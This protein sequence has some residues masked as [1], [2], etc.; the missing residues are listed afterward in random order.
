MN[1][2]IVIGVSVYSDYKNNLPGCKNDATAI[3]I[4]LQKTGKFQKILY[5]NENQSSAET[6]ELITNF[7]LEFKGKEIDEFFFYYS[8][9]G[10]FFNNEFYY[11]LSDFDSKKRNQSSLQN[12]EM[13]DLIKTL[14]PNLVI[15]VIDACQSGTTYIKESDSVNKYFNETTNTFKKCYFL[16]SSLNDQSSYQ[17]KNISFFTNSFII[18]LKE[19]KSTE[20]RYKDII[21][22]I[23]D[24]FASINE[25]TP[26]FITQAEFTE[27]FCSFSSDLREYLNTFQSDT[28]Q[29]DVTSI[30]DLIKE[31]AKE[32]VDQKG[33]V[34]SLNFVK[35]KFSSLKLS[36]ELSS[37]YE[38]EI[39]FLENYQPVPRKG[40]IATWIKEHKGEYFAVPVYETEY[41]H[42]IQGYDE[43]LVGFDL[44]IDIPFKAISLYILAKFPNL[45]SYQSTVVFLV[46][47]RFIRFFYF[48]TD[49]IEQGW[50]D[51][52]LN[53][54]AIRWI[55][56]E[57]V[58]ND[59]TKIEESITTIKESIENKI[60]MDIKNK[61]KFTNDIEPA[62]DA[63]I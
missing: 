40:L 63:H 4:I 62:R 34:A 24:A 12:K 19:H 47:K 15:K 27:K 32:Y 54:S 1:I 45:A 5:I 30:Y 11:V 59:V 46:S 17:D 53:F 50:E 18:A 13:D 37:I 51:K 42:E 3:N 14:T 57:C 22:I 60:E 56:E 41:D 7:I 44:K 48:I 36:S 23:S 2:A 38:A 52:K 43:V 9:H 25:Q 31:N 55:S 35:E 26:L 58:I 10:E 61:F 49:Y 39:N 29:A 16:N 8:G 6:K 28:P 33:A 21:D 20:I